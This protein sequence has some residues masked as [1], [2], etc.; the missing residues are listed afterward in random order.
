MSTIYICTKR[1]FLRTLTAAQQSRLIWIYN[2]GCPRLGLVLGV[3]RLEWL[4]VS[5]SHRLLSHGFVACLLMPFP[6]GRV[7]IKRAGP[8]WLAPQGLSS[9]PPSSPMFLSLYSVW[10]VSL[11]CLDAAL[12]DT[13]APGF[14]AAP[15]RSSFA[16]ISESRVHTSVL[17]M[18]LFPLVVLLYAKSPWADVSQVPP[19]LH[20][21]R[22]GNAETCNWL[23]EDLMRQPQQ[24]RNMSD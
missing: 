18:T 23:A 24:Y 13:E 6:F 5:I 2:A 20:R 14:G 4:R 10:C 3:C 22:N 19:W 9:L 12:P 15:W 11:L 16:L 7:C 17:F 8:N 1:V 21:M